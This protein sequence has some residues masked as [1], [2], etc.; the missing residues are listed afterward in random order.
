M[1]MTTKE[2]EQWYPQMQA[3]SKGIDPHKF[4]TQLA[5]IVNSI[6]LL[7]RYYKK[8]EDNADKIKYYEDLY[9]RSIREV[10][11]LLKENAMRKIKH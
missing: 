2:Y 11:R 5:Y 7:E 9:D 1:R 10:Q 6:A 4:N 8:P 3:Q